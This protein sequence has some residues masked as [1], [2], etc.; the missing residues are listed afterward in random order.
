[1]EQKDVNVAQTRLIN[2]KSRGNMAKLA[3]IQPWPAMASQH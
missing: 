1:M 2:A 3:T